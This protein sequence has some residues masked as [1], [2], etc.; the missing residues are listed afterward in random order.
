MEVLALP[1]AARTGPS[2]GRPEAPETVLGHPAGTPEALKALRRQALEL[3]PSPGVY[4]MMD[5]AGT[6]IYVG[7]AKILPRR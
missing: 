7:K 1:A 4:L 5:E 2:L 6:V 3:P